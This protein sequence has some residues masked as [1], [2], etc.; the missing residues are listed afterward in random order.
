[1]LHD[2]EFF[3][4]WLE[5]KGSALT[6]GARALAKHAER[7]RDRYWGILGGSGEYLLGF[8]SL[9]Q[10]SHV[11]VVY[12]SHLCVNLLHVVL[13]RCILGLTCFFLHQ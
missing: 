8:Q 4:D 1:V 10:N 9:N 5:I 6:H 2:S 12:R 13:F 11:I 3:L 7:S